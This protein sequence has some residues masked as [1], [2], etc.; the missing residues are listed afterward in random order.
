M[1]YTYTNYNYPFGGCRTGFS[2]DSARHLARNIQIAFLPIATSPSATRPPMPTMSQHHLVQAER[3]TRTPRN[4]VATAERGVVSPRTPLGLM[5]PNSAPT[6]AGAA[7]NPKRAAVKKAG[8]KSATTPLA[9]PGSRSRSASPVIA[10]RASPAAQLAKGIMKEAGARPALSPNTSVRLALGFLGL[11][12]G[13]LPRAAAKAD[14]TTAAPPVAPNSALK[15]T[16]AELLEA[17]LR[18]SSG[19]AKCAEAQERAELEALKLAEAERAVRAAEAKT[20]RELSGVR[21]ELAGSREAASGLLAQL[22]SESAAALEQAKK[23]A[24]A[25]KGDALLA[26]AA[27]DEALG[28]RGRAEEAA[29]R[30]VESGVAAARATVAAQAELALVRT[31]AGAAGEAW[32]REKRKLVAL[33]SVSAARAAQEVRLR[34][35]LPSPPPRPAQRPT[36]HPIAPP[37]SI[38]STFTGSRSAHIKHF[39]WGLFYSRGACILLSSAPPGQ[40]PPTHTHHPFGTAQLHP[41]VLRSTPPGRPTACNNSLASSCFS[42]PDAIPC[43]SSAFLSPTNIYPTASL[44]L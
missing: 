39:L 16:R 12:A 42:Q 3:G 8:V 6:S 30:A 11:G 43:A 26:A 22:K 34:L 44:S 33:S 27:L 20:E 28:T 5:S 2:Y 32:R 1:T 37:S 17:E 38:P 24:A 15:H 4:V 25:A 21:T 36:W 35:T 7:T 41:F 18:C 13:R 29:V 9:K 14:G 40:R 10:W 23:E 31:E 19:R